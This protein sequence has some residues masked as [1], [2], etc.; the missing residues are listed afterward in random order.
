MQQSDLHPVV[1]RFFAVALNSEIIL[2]TSV[3]RQTMQMMQ[4]GL[5]LQLR[6]CE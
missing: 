5:Q 6:S 3:H 2:P 1:A 4:D